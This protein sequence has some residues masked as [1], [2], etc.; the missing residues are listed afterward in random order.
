M[1][2]SALRAEFP[3]LADRAY[4]NAGT[5]GPLPGAA[6]RASLEMLDRAAGEGRAKEYV[7][8]LIELRGR[9]RAA[10]AGTIGADP[11]DV[12]LTTCTSD[13][14]VRVLGG[15]ELGPNDEVLTAPDEHPGLL[16]PL[17]TLR[18]R[19]GVHIRTAPFADL[20][21]AV[22]PRTRLVACSHVSWVTGAVRPEGLAALDVPVLLD[23]A[24]GVGAIGFDVAALG[25]AFYA[26][27]GQKWLCGPIGSGMLWVAS[28][29]HK[30]LAP[31]G[32]TYLNLEDAG[33]GLA[34]EP[35]AD[36]RRYDAPGVSA[37]T[38]AAA[39]VA[40]D[41]LARSG[42]P[43]VHARAAALAALLAER[44]TAAGRTVAPRADTTLVSFE[45]ADPE[46]TRDRLAAAGVI[47]RH[48]PGTPYVRA[49]VGAWNDEGD[50]ERLLTAL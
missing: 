14:I 32:A 30:R 34:A 1:D 7:E 33:A 9:Q 21:D 28:D 31:I 15:L 20:A 26:G 44:L 48:L 13:G 25:C 2:A 43:E 8:A 11:A 23:G 19:R 5:C 47:V 16:G 50:L 4:L 41:V 46:A 37:E 42:W 38:L 12:A 40:H 45:D 49:S 27:S 35:Y 39:V 10:Y 22:G 18:A 29:W 6:V 17:A 3:V 24:Q 36:A